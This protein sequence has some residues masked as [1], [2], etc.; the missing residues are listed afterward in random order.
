MYNCGRVPT[1]ILSTSIPKFMNKEKGYSPT[2]CILTSD[3]MGKYLPNFVIVNYVVFRW[4]AE[5]KKK[6]PK[7]TLII[8]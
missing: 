1:Y 4:M 3:K 8:N 6:I 5:E 2:D 7:E